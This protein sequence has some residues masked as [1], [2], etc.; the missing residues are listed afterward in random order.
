MRK[1]LFAALIAAFAVCMLSCG[2]TKSDFDWL[3][4]EKTEAAAVSVTPLDFTDSLE[5]TGTIYDYIEISF[6]S[7]DGFD[8]AEEMIPGFQLLSSDADAGRAA[9][10][11]LEV[12]FASEFAVNRENAKAWGSKRFSGEISEIVS[13]AAKQEIT[14]PPDLDDSEFQFFVK[15]QALETSDQGV[16]ELV[17][18][19]DT[20][21]NYAYN[22]KMK[23]LVSY[24]EN[25][26]FSSI[27]EFAADSSL[28]ELLSMTPITGAPTAETAT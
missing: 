4:P 23:E 11:L 9:A 6:S 26:A 19:V 21:E 7:A 13:L 27:A 20:Y 22:L 25:T 5:K 15:S 24:L 17:K 2:S 3:S 16:I 14:I 18:F 12:R 10:G 28:H 8:G 1:I